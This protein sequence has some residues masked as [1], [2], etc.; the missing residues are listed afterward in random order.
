MEWI[1]RSLGAW[2][3]ARAIDSVTVANTTLSIFSDAFQ[4]SQLGPVLASFVWRFLL[5][6]G[7]IIVIV[8]LTLAIALGVLTCLK[9]PKALTWLWGCVAWLWGWLLVILRILFGVIVGVGTLSALLW[10]AFGHYNM[11]DNLLTWNA[12]LEQS[13]SL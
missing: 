7:T 5:S 4:K 8:A 12:T 1:L 10:F 11:I 6:T 9:L 2:I 3:D 13:V